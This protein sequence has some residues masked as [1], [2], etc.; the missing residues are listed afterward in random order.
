[1]NTYMDVY[2]ERTAPG[3]L[4]EPLNA[5]TNASFLIA[6]W[7]A[8][9]L[10]TRSGHV[11]GD[12]LSLLWLSVATGIGS[13][14]WHTFATAWS[15]ILDVIPILLFLVGFFWLYLRGVA[16]VPTPF[17]VAAIAV[18]LLA[19]V[20][21]QAVGSVLHGA[22]YY[23]PALIFLFALGVYHASRRATTSLSLLAAAGAMGLALVFRT[24]DQ[25]VCPS[26]PI[27]THFLWHSL[28]GLAAYLAMRCLILNH[29]VQAGRRV[30]RALPTS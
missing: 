6:A 4:A 29:A 14:L 26:F 9:Y 19:T 12:I 10:A 28:S 17:V 18:F 16:S 1:V 23:T 24:I 21:A 20:S 22:L 5:I 2:C 11:S 3:L 7:A 27:G 13:G 25:E 8:W 15:L 30:S